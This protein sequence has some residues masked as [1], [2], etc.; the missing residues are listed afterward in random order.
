MS[1]SPFGKSSEQVRIETLEKQV[2]VLTKF[3]RASTIYVSSDSGRV[4]FDNE[5][6]E[7]SK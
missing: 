4:R 7:A 3:V 5:M 2:Q 6:A 1:Y